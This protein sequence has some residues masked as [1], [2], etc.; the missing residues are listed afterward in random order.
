MSDKYES[1]YDFLHQYSSAAVSD[2]PDVEDMTDEELGKAFQS[3]DQWYE[4]MV[5]ELL[6]RAC[7]KD[8]D[9]EEWL[10]DAANDNDFEDWE[11]AYDKAAQILGIDL[12]GF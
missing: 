1:V 9:F 12:Y 3:V 5:N 2:F 11:G 10:L 8:D 6:G 4:D 7:Q